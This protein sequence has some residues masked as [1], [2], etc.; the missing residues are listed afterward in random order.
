LSTGFAAEDIAMMTAQHGCVQLIHDHNM[1]LRRA[2]CGGSN[3]TTPRSSLPPSATA[4]PR[5]N[6][7]TS[8]FGLPQQQNFSDGL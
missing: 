4:T 2:G 7:V 5:D 3:N 1:K 8:D 6:T